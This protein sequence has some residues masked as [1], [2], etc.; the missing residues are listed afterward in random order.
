MT[1]FTLSG[2][3]GQETTIEAVDRDD[4]CLIA[5]RFGLRYGEPSEE[6]FRRRLIFFLRGGFGLLRFR[7]DPVRLPV[8]RAP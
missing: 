5:R 6:L 4:A 8:T 3:G 1:K 7:C 2:P